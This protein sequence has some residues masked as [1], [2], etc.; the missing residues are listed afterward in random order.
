M[1]DNKIRV[2]IIGAGKYGKELIA[3]KYLASPACQLISVVSKSKSS[4]DF[5]G[6]ALEGIPVLKSMDAWKKK[7]GSPHSH[8]V[9]DICVPTV[10]VIKTVNALGRI[11]AKKIILPKPVAVTQKDLHNLSSMIAKYEMKA[12]VS[13][14]WHYSGITHALAAAIN[15][16][17]GIRKVKV[18]FSQKLDDKRFPHYDSINMLLPHIIQILESISFKLENFEVSV[19]ELSKHRLVA[20]LANTAGNSLSIEIITD[21]L[22]EKHVRKVWVWK[23]ETKPVIV[24][25]FM[26]RYENNHIVEKPS[27]TIRG[28]KR[29]FN[30]DTL[31]LMVNQNL[32]YFSTKTNNALSY[33]K[34]LPVARMI[35]KIVDAASARV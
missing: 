9:F 6:T 32:K 4:K 1:V 34:Y 27:L 10:E 13:S 12:V 14:Q 15:G 3:P 25:D 26:A 20:T 5:A 18:E 24:A 30:E 11:G 2:T 16:E 35:L 7:F 31:A 21:L 8:D 19:D 22:A 17:K 33:K 28:K 29:S 23:N